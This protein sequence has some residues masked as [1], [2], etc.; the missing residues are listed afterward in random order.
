M[1]DD[2]CKRFGELCPSRQSSPIGKESRDVM[3]SS[4]LI[5]IVIVWIILV[6]AVVV[7]AATRKPLSNEDETP[8]SKYPQY[9]F[10]SI[11]MMFGVVS[12]IVLGLVLG[13]VSGGM[14]IGIGFGLIIGQMLEKRFGANVRPLTEQE[15]QERLNRAGLGL[16]AVFILVLIT[17]LMAIL[18]LF[19]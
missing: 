1:I 12:G 6:L 10:L 19:K 9:F 4:A 16:I 15:K 8:R 2:A 14:A 3:Q 7:F 13:S 11:G 5:P 17:L 18:P